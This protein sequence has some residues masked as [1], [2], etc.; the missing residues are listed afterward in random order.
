ML[1]LIVHALSR[2]VKIPRSLQQSPVLLNQ[3]S[4]YPARLE[5]HLAQSLLDRVVGDLDAS[6]LE[7]SVRLQR[8]ELQRVAKIEYVFHDAAVPIDLLVR[9]A[10]LKP[11]STGHKQRGN[12]SY[13][14][15]GGNI[16]WKVLGDGLNS[17]NHCQ[18][19]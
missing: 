4:A 18:I 3:T 14:T 9:L 12:G 16:L 10:F 17:P 13:I 1:T 2:K 5:V 8:R 15:R 7:F 6:L 19:A 11:A